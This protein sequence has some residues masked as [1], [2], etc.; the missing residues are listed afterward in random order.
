M[1][2]A[3]P[4]QSWE[5]HGVGRKLILPQEMCYPV[6]GGSCSCATHRMR[7]LRDVQEVRPFILG[8]CLGAVKDL[9]ASILFQPVYFVALPSLCPSAAGGRD[10]GVGAPNRQLR[11]RARP[12]STS[13]K[14]CCAS[15]L[16]RTP[17]AGTSSFRF[18]RL[19]SLRTRCS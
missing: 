18:R 9:K 12:I 13:R 19:E 2:L 14:S 8:Q 7:F 16:S 1:I 17:D 5:V 4:R 11:Q 10:E 6:P 15:S 3:A